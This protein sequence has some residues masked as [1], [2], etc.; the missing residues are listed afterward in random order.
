[1]NYKKDIIAGSALLAFAVA[2]VALSFGIPTFQGIG[3]TPLTAQFVPQLWGT[4]LI[5]LSSTLLVRGIRAYRKAK[6]T[7]PEAAKKPLPQA[8]REF[9][10]RN[11]EVILTFA[12]LFVYILLLDAVG[13]IIMSALFMFA[14]MMVLSPKEKRKVLLPAIL[15]VV[16]SVGLDYVFVV[17]L[18]VLLPQGILGF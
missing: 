11:R 16:F 13:F 9:A 5:I 10:S 6:P 8:I 4:A 2:Y 14:L 7:Q 17:L 1:M 3:A 12:V 18:R 15:S